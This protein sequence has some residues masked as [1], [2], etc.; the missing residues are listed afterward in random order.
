MDLAKR[1][2]TSVS[3]E[4]GVC[5]MRRSFRVVQPRRQW[6]KDRAAPCERPKVANHTL[7]EDGLDVE[8]RCCRSGA[9]CRDVRGARHHRTRTIMRQRCPGLAMCGAIV[10]CTA[11]LAGASDSGTQGTSRAGS[12]PPAGI[13]ASDWSGIMTAREAS[14]HA[15]HAS[16]GGGHQAWN[17]GQGWRLIFDDRGFSARPSRGVAGDWWWGLELTSVGFAGHERAVNSH[18]VVRADGQRLAYEWSSTLT[19]W[20]INDHR[21]L[22]HGFTL[23]DRP[24][25]GAGPLRIR[26][27][28][29]GDLCAEVHDDRDAVRFVNSDGTVVLNYAGLVVFEADG[30][31]VPAHFEV[32]LDALLLVVDERGARY[33]LTIDPIAQQAYLKASNTG[34]GDLFGASVGVSGDTVVVGAYGEDGSASGVNGD[35][36][37]NGSS[38]AGAAYVFVRSN[39]AWSQQAYLKASNTGMNDWFGYSVAIS[40]DTI[41]V[42]ARLEDGNSTGVNGDQSNNSAIDAGAAYV[43]ARTDG[44][45]SQQAYLKA[46]N[47]GAVDVFGSSVAVDGDTVIVGAYGEDG[48]APGVNGDQASNG[49]LSSGAVYV[50]TRVDG[51]WSQQAYLKAS[52]PAGGD[53]FGWSIGV[54]GDTVVVGAIKEDSSAMGVNGDQSNNGA[55]DSGAAY[56]FSRNGAIWSQQ[57]YLKASNTGSNDWFGYSVAVSGDSA[58]VGANREDSSAMGVNGDQDDNGAADSGAAYVF[59]GVDGTWS[60]QAYLKASN[61]GVVNAFGASLSID[62]DA[63]VV[64][65][66]HEESSATGVGGDQSDNSA[67]SSGAAYVYSRSA[68]IWTQL[69]YLK[70]SNTGAN[71]FFGWSVGVS[72]DTVVV[73][74]NH[75]AGSATGINGNQADDSAV[76]AGA[77]YMF[78]LDMTSFTPGDLNDDGLVDGDDLGTLLGQWGECIDCSADFN[79]DEVVDGDDLGVLLGAWT[80]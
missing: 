17:P 22:E 35:Q 77:G 24:T 34:I 69:A 62:A 71:D 4:I 57:A 56:L 54:S 59:L 40:G 37:S 12:T 63:I 79:R 78:D 46:S 58:V 65:A 76:E 14:Q 44:V 74:A 41:V 80:S 5:A 20:F 6:F 15:I 45:W 11:A 43:F 64:G 49:A 2:W 26:L 8:F 32:A 53:D 33:P 13:A 52:N 68:G 1:Q 16:G 50:F 7:D 25:D 28:I 61:S 36:S 30:S 73:G 9:V 31:R 27:T 67:P 48:A 66:I 70:A 29:R 10:G 39:G 18:P 42:G 38:N 21:G 19:E 72:G 51:V 23:R 55:M 3:S 75:E 47:T 60:Q